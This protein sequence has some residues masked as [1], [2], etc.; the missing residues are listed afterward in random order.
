MG[1]SENKNVETYKHLEKFNRLFFCVLFYSVSYFPIS[2]HAENDLEEI[3]KKRNQEEIALEGKIYFAKKSIKISN[4][5]MLRLQRIAE[6]LLQNPKFVIY[7]R[8]HSFDGGT[9]KEE[10]S[11]SEKRSIEVEKFFTLHGV[12]ETQIRRLFYGN[13]RPSP[14]VSISHDTSLMRRVEYQIITE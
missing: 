8:A 6:H 13:F 2:L 11:I 9:E 7:I 3:G 12:K 5:D 14:N 10:I 4:Y 1:L